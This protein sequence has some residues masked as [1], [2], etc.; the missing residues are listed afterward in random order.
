MKTLKLLFLT[1]L[2]PLV[3]SAQT[4]IFSENCGNPAITTTC[5]TYTGWQNNG[6][7]TFTASA[8]GPDVRTTLPSSGYAGASGNGN[9]FFINAVTNRFVQI[10]SIN[11][12][13]YT[14]ISLTFAILK[15][16]N[17]STGSE[18]VVEVSTNGS[19][20]TAL[21]YSLATGSGTSNVYTLKTPTGTIP[22]TGNLRIRFRYTS[23][24]STC[25][26]RIDDIKLSGCLIPSAPTV[27]CDT[28]AC[29]SSIVYLPPNSYLQ[30]L[31]N[32]TSTS[33]S[34]VIYASGTYYARTV[35]TV[36]GCSLVWSQPTTI[37]TTIYT[38]PQITQS[39]EPLVLIY[40]TNT[41]VYFTAHATYSYIWQTSTDD[42]LT[43]N[44]LTI[45]SPFSTNGDTLF[46]NF[47]G[48]NY[49]LDGDRFRIVSTNN[50]CVKQS[51]YGLLLIS[52]QLPVELIGFSASQN[53]DLVKLTWT[54]A[55]ETNNEKFEIERSKDI[56]EWEKIGSI[57]G[58]G[59]SNIYLLYSFHDLYPIKGPSYYRLKQIDYDG[60][61]E[62]SDIIAV[63]FLTKTNTPKKYYDLNGIEVHELKLNVPYIETDGN[64]ARKIILLK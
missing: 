40:S 50:T 57:D 11:T 25:Q 34:N 52:I 7:L 15:T 47:T 29:D 39:P 43:W 10:S 63:N 62:Y 17:T 19:T 3:V 33:T 12:S 6:T 14:N 27:T 20:Y 28:P 44:N 56:Q 24:T 64:E 5:T 23:T 1:F 18:L 13:N 60:G 32:G 36:Y 58:A 4:T 54:T 9:I 51:D 59:F 46:I 2:L 45:A 42:G 41:T 21:S 8:T 53:D 22:S 30:S 49:G 16:T 37:N 26:F 35:S 38:T 48:S 55:T 31:P 61:Y